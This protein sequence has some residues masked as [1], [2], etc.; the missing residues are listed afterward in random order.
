MESITDAGYKHAK[1]VWIDFGLQNLSQY[2]KL[3]DTMLLSDTLKSFKNKCL[4][5]FEQ[6]PANF[7]SEHRLASR[8][9][10]RKQRWN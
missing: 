10:S 5:T 2:H 3:S 7:V 1:I 8:D 6:H 9:V 4:K